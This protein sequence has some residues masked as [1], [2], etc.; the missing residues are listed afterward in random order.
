ME[1]TM[2][3][4]HI[5]IIILFIAG[6]YCMQHGFGQSRERKPQVLFQPILEG[7]ELESATAFLREKYGIT[8]AKAPILIPQFRPM[9]ISDDLYDVPEDFQHNSIYVD[10]RNTTGIIKNTQ[11]VVH[12][13]ALP[14]SSEVYLRNLQNS[15]SKSVIDIICAHHEDNNLALQEL[16]YRIIGASSMGIGGLASIHKV[17]NEPSLGDFC[18]ALIPQTDIPDSPTESH[19]ILFVRNGTMFFVWSTGLNII[20]LAEYLDKKYVDLTAELN[21]PPAFRLWTL[22]DTEEQIEAKYQSSTDTETTLTNKDGELIK[23]EMSRL[24]KPD[25]LYVQRRMEIARYEAEQKA[26]DPPGTPTD[27]NGV[28]E[29]VDINP[30]TPVPPT[31]KRGSVLVSVVVTFI[32]LGLLA[33]GVLCFVRYYWR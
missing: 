10:V 23:I 9:L 20:P 30:N 8:V 11:M 3:P 27:S 22:S 7:S 19:K 14:I 2:K 1:I 28:P 24:S 21:N 15:S 17:L 12:S 26:S 4:L 18:V 25:Q 6:T 16:L 29:N 31:A 13:T 33:Y 32:I 5:T